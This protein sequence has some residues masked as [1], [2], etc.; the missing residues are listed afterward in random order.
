MILLDI[1]LKKEK[2]C[3]N[4][5]ITRI[6]ESWLFVR[7]L[8]V[9]LYIPFCWFLVGKDSSSDEDARELILSRWL[10]DVSPRIWKNIESSL[11]W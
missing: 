4:P 9:N 6:K 2:K 10:E 11:C 1:G 3:V 5:M 8:N 7:K